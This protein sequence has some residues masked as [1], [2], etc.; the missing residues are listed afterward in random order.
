ML[1]FA[2]IANVVFLKEASSKKSLYVA[3]FSNVLSPRPEARAEYYSTAERS[4]FNFHLWGSEVVQ[5]KAAGAQS[6]PLTKSASTWSSRRKFPHKSHC[7]AD[8]FPRN[9][10]L[11]TLLSDGPDAACSSEDAAVDSDCWFS[12]RE[13][14]DGS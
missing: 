13:T 9:R 7:C 6:L 11:V 4:L 5:T 3:Y 10:H 12:S 2:C 14:M 1:R 8:M